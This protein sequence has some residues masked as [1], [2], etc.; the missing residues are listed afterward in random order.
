MGG[1]CVM[2]FHESMYFTHRFRIYSKKMYS[3]GIWSIRLT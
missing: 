3:L 2:Q 1:T